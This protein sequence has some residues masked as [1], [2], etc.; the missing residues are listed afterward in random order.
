MTK[1]LTGYMITWTTYGT[2]LQGDKRGYVKNGQIVPGDLKIE[3]NC[4][5]LQEGTTVTLNQKERK[6]AAQTILKE[7]EKIGQAIKA[8]TVCNNHVH[9]VAQPCC[10]SI[11]Q[12][13]SRYKNVAMFA[14]Y[15]CGRKGRIWTHGFDKRFC[16]NQEELARKIKYVQKHQKKVIS[17]MPPT[18]GVGANRKVK[19]KIDE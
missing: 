13:V 11:E 9:I 1:K 15:K 6:I 7:A 3:E 16:F 10:E 5:K 17:L 14:L 12:I 18:A 19:G 8:L 2:W 4:K